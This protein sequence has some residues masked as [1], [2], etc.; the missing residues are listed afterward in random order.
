LSR[1]L[2]A[3]GEPVDQVCVSH[4]GRWC[5]FLVLGEISSS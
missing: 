1:V 4:G 5:G 3:G 2:A